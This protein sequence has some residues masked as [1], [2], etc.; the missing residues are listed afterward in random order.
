MIGK[1]AVRSYRLSFH[2]LIVVKINVWGWLIRNFLPIPLKHLLEG[3]V[4]CR[5]TND[6][7][8]CCEK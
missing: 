3:G 4:I 5:S 2:T 6:G 8:V 7:Q 1:G